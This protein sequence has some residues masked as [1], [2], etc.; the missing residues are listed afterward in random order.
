MYAQLKRL[1]TRLFLLASN[2]TKDLVNSDPFDTYIRLNMKQIK[3]R[4]KMHI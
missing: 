4:F 3:E 2:T 1:R